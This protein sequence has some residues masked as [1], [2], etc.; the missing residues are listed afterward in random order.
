M[1]G[2]HE[3]RKLGVVDSVMSVVEMRK[4]GM[5]RMRFVGV[6]MPWWMSI[7][8]KLKLRKAT[9]GARK[10]WALVADYVLCRAPR[11]FEAL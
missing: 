1:E 9:A 3:D 8:A 2:E 10:R 5:R 7:G 11:F 6:Q 4:C